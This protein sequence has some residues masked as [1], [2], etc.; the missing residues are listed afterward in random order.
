M[1]NTCKGPSMPCMRRRASPTSASTPAPAC[2][3]RRGQLRPRFR[4]G[5]P[6]ILPSPA[7]PDHARTTRTGSTTK[8]E[9]LPGPPE[10]VQCNSTALRRRLR[11]LPSRRGGRVAG[12]IRQRRQVNALHAE[13]FA[14]P[15][16]G[17]RLAESGPEAQPR[18]GLRLRRRPADRVRQRGLGRRGARLRD[19]RPGRRRSAARRDR[20]P[21]LEVAVREAAAA[22]CEWL[23]VD[24]EEELR[25]FYFGACGFRPRRPG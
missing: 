25:D 10:I 11:L 8:G 23:H 17:H 18:L 20:P 14:H 13:G 3:T 7:V 12:T 5:W 24:F 21:L 19:R 15:V 4:T 1:P 9:H 6:T 2:G 22:G 16:P